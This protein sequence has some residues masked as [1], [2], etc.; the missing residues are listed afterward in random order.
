[1]HQPDLTPKIH[2]L[3]GG[4]ALSLQLEQGCE[5]FCQQG[6]L[7]LAISPLDFSDHHF[8]QILE[9]HTGQSWRCPSNT[10]V[11]LSAV[12]KT[13]SVQ[14]LQVHKEQSRLQT[15]M[16]SERLQGTKAGRPAVARIWQQLFKLHLRRG[17]R[18]VS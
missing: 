7:R 9:L 12:G 16:D 6:P 11:Q 2:R 14:S 15:N 8:S 18:E 1:M 5:L 17:Q 4:L 13:A 10:W 3:C